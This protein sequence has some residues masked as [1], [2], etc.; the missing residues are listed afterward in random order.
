MRGNG[1][2]FQRGDVWWVDYYHNGRELRESSGSN[3]RRKAEQL[4]R[5]RL[6]KAGTPE[7]VGP[8]AQRLTFDDL[9]AMY[10]TDYRIN[11]KRSLRD[12]KRN[13]E[14]LRTAFGFDR[15]MSITADRIAAYASRRLEDRMSAAS[16]NR[17][18]AACDACSR[19]R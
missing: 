4:L 1:R 9:A 15:A 13:V 11:A 3:D 5:E 14:Q 19:S 18:L 16:V 7:F 8:A 10:L 12:A 6:R 2:V 17:E